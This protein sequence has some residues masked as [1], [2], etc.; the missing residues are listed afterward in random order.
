[1]DYRR[2]QDYKRRGLKRLLALCLL[3]TLPALADDFTTTDGVKHSGKITRVEPD[4]L[5]LMTDSGV[6]KVPFAALPADVQK[7]YGYD[8]AKSAAFQQAIAAN[9]AL[10]QSTP[11]DPAIQAQLLNLPQQ[12]TSHSSSGVVQFDYE[13]IKAATAAADA[14]KLTASIKPIS[15]GDDQTTVDIQPVVSVQTGT[16]QEMLNVVN[17]Y[18]YQNQGDNF[19]GVI[20]SKM[21][22]AVQSG[23]QFIIVLYAIGH[24]DDSA[25]DPLYTLD[26]QHAVNYWLSAK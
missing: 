21:P 2:C 3:A 1:M 11:V 23:D 18:A 25:R 17:D 26:R 15:F 9:Y 16:H 6:E 10:R 7:K 24:T 5:M 4:G 19:T 20:D 12:P 14:N 22:N 13:N 8:P